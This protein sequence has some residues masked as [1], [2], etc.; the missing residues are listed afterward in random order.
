MA[1]PGSFE[2]LRFLGI[3]ITSVIA[4]WCDGYRA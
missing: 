3:S 1:E 4:A 2:P